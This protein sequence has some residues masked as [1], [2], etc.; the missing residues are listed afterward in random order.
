MGKT[1]TEIVEEIEEVL[2]ND[3]IELDYQIEDIKEI[4][5]D[6][7]FLKF[8]KYL[9]RGDYNVDQKE[10]MRNLVI[11]AMRRLNS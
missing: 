9:D 6:D 11:N 5:E 10:Q 7:L 2:K 8:L 1:E 3:N 4:L